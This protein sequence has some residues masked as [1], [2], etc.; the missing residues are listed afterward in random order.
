MRR[1]GLQEKMGLK[2]EENI[3]FRESNYEVTILTGTHRLNPDDDNVDV[4]VDFTDGRSY[5]ATFFTILNIHTLFEKNRKT[6]ECG[7]GRYF[8]CSDMVIVE[9][10]TIENIR[11]TIFDLERTGEIDSAMSL[12]PYGGEPAESN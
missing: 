7:W 8:Y 5:T 12:S 2:S 9:T 6:G 10:L 4:F 11:Q 1:T 3:K